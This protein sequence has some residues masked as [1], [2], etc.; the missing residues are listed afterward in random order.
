VWFDEPVLSNVEGPVLSNVEGLTTNGLIKQYGGGPQGNEV[1]GAGLPAN[2]GAKGGAG[3]GLLAVGWWFAAV[4]FA[5]KPA[6]TGGPATAIYLAPTQ[7]CSLNFDPFACRKKLIEGL[8]R[9][10]LKDLKT[11]QQTRPIVA[12]LLPWLPHTFFQTDKSP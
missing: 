10:L 9:C 11:G 6:P 3:A 5:G 8:V 12:C 4:R 7:Y 2:A 1:V